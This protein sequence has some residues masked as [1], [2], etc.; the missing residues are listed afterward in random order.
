MAEA[1]TPQPMDVAGEGLSYNYCV[2]RK[3]VNQNC[4]NTLYFDCSKFTYL[5]KK[6]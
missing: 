5:C 3:E 1:R 6:Q 2:L 4:C